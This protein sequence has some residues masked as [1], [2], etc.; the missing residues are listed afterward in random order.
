M[1]K[2]AIRI[3]DLTVAYNVTP[4]LWDIDL[5]IPKNKLTAIIGPNGAGK[6]TLIKSILNL[7]KP[8]SGTIDLAS[9]KVA[10][11]PQTTSIDWD[12]PITVKDVVLMGTYKDLGWFKKPSKKEYKEVDEVL[13]K[14]GMLEYKNRQIGQ[15]SGGQQQRVFIAR[16]LIQKADLFFLDEPLKGVDSQTEKDIISLLKELKENSMGVVVVHH[17]LQTVEKYFDY[18]VLINKK[19]IATGDVET[20]FNKSNLDKTYS[21][22]DVL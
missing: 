17:D 20:T 19:I 2:L 6:S 5:N 9:N 11:I 7:I 13:K 1:N 14:V 12:F 22:G 4:V 21:D 8:I 15:L 10:Y 3:E 16:A 18:I